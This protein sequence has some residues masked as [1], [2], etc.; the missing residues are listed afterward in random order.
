MKEKGGRSGREENGN[1]EGAKKRILVVVLVNGMGDAG[2]C[3]YRSDSKT[4]PQHNTC[5]IHRN[6]TQHNT[7]FFVSI[8][9]G[10]EG[11]G[12]EIG[13]GRQF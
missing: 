11:W 1:G 6:K 8:L 3:V 2:K 10:L 12:N 5:L 13:L 7:C 9:F 4:A